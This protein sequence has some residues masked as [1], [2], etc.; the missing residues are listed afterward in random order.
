M[1]ACFQLVRPFGGWTV[2]ERVEVGAINDGYVWLW[3]YP[4]VLNPYGHRDWTACVPLKGWLKWVKPWRE[5]PL[6]T[7]YERVLSG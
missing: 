4:E 7:R 2:G 1:G 3:T 6:P 5:V